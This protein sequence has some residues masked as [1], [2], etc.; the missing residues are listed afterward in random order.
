AHDLVVHRLPASERR[1]H[2]REAPEHA[3][4]TIEKPRRSANRASFVKGPSDGNRVDILSQLDATGYLGLGPPPLVRG[5]RPSGA[6]PVTLLMARSL[7]VAPEPRDA[8]SLH[9]SLGLRPTGSVFLDQFLP[10]CRVLGFVPEATPTPTLLTV[11]FQTP[12]RIFGPFPKRI[13]DRDAVFQRVEVCSVVLC[14]VVPDV[15][16]RIHTDQVP[17]CVVAPIVVDMVAVRSGFVLVNPISDV[18]LVSHPVRRFV[19]AGQRLKRHL[20][21]AEH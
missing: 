1:D 3:P 7:V 15:F 12:L 21:A 14:V 13:T 11:T 10:P 6:R 17:G 8:L 18:P 4:V 2:V 19:E 16:R 5:L 9:L 20:V